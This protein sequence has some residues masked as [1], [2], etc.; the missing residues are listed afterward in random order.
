MHDT[1]NS[2]RILRVF[3]TKSPEKTNGKI[4]MDTYYTAT[5]TNNIME[6]KN[7]INDLNDFLRSHQFEDKLLY[8]INLAIEEPLINIIKY[9]RK[10]DTPLEIQ[11]EV[12]LNQEDVSIHLTDNGRRFNPLS[13]PHLDIRKPAIERPVGGLGMHLVR[14]IMQS[15]WYER[16]DDKNIF[17]VNIAR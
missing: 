2:Y 16:R 3:K 1:K 12:N 7:I 15:M 10:E 13:V 9:G 4:V 14:N 6:M 11:I 5:M 8:Q 17:R